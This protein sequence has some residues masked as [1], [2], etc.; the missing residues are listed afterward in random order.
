[1]LDQ[2]DT[3]L[4]VFLAGAGGAGCSL[5]SSP[6]KNWVERGGGLPNYIC[7]IARAVMRSGKSKS[8]A[9]AIAVSRT[10]KWAAGGDDVDADTRAKAAKAVAQWEALKAKNKAKKVVKA[11]RQGDDAEYLMLSNIGSFNTEMVRRAWDAEERVRRHAYEAEHE[12][13]RD[14]AAPSST[15]YPYRWVR[16]LWSDFIIVESETERAQSAFL[17]I[18]YTVVGGKVVFGE[19]DTVEQVWQ[20]I[21][22]DGL[23]D[24]DINEI[25]RALLQDVLVL[26]ASHKS[27]LEIIQ[28]IA[29]K[30]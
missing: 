20:E 22:D 11:S 7:R 3:D 13:A 9:I 5:D 16:E 28:G 12:D 24:D 17:K 15:L 25:E 2:H 26:S 8:S 1:M 29:Q 6:K 14:I 21:E 27:Y 18:P 30:K 23:D 4:V 19:P 10:K